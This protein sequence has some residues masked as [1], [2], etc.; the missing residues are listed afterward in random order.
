M[1]SLTD[2]LL[3]IIKIDNNKGTTHIYDHQI[4]LIFTQDNFEFENIYPKGHDLYF[5][6]SQANILSH[7]IESFDP[8]K[9]HALFWVKVPNIPSQTESKIYLY[10]GEIDHTRS[11]GNNTF[12]FFDDFDVLSSTWVEYGSVLT[13]SQQGKVTWFVT[14][15]FFSKTTSTTSGTGTQVPRSD[16]LRHK[17]DITERNMRIIQ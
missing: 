3:R 10:Q 4:K 13:P 6:D 7:W 11:N 5:K 12:D 16:M 9:Q 1:D 14:L 8:I 2:N 17:M 15:L